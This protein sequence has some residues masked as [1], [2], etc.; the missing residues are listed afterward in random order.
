M[1]LAPPR[2]SCVNSGRFGHKVTRETQR[3][4]YECLSVC[5]FCVQSLV[6]LIKCW[7]TE[8]VKRPQRRKENVAFKNN[9]VNVFLGERLMSSLNI[10]HLLKMLL[11]RGG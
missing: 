3:I 8:A 7:C 9:V 5:W 11:N 1:N 6:L 4:V 10:C 2:H